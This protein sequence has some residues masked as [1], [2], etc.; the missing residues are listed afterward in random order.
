MS[1]SSSCCGSQHIFDLFQ[2]AG[3]NP[4]EFEYYSLDENYCFFLNY[5]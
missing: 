4:Q 5:W 2:S 1:R 3:Y